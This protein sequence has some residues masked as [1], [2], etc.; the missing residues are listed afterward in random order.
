MTTPFIRHAPWTIRVLLFRII[1][2]VISFLK[3]DGPI[4]TTEQSAFYAL[5][6]AFDSSPVFGEFPKDLYFYGTEPRGTSIESRD[7][8]KRDLVWKTSVR[9]A[10]LKEGETVLGD[11]Q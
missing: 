11:W 1:F 9:L 2:P 6:A 3:P 7:V 8:Q 4:R 5:Q 10:Q